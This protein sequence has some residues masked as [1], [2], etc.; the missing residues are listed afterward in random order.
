MKVWFTCNAREK[1]G[2]K[3]MPIYTSKRKKYQKGVARG[4]GR[5]PPN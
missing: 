5:I 4:K 1:E 2:Q 3:D